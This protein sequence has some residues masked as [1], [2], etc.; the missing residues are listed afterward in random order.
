ML[1][2]N[3]DRCTPVWELQ[4]A[5]EI[6]YMY[7]CITKLCRTQAEVIPN[8]VNPNVHGLEQGEARQR[9]RQKLGDRPATIQQTNSSSEY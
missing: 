2:G 7:D 5:F 1:T 6:P 4:V 9:K 8:H 3:L